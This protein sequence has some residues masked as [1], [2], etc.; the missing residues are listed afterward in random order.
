VG[1]IQD[2]CAPHRTS[3]TRLGGS[4][5]RHSRSVQS[6]P[7]HPSQWP[8][9][10]VRAPDKLYY[11]DKCL[12]FGA[13]PSA[14]A[15]GHVADAAAEI[16][17]SEG[18]GP[19]DKWVDDHVFFCVKWVHL[20]NYNDC[21]TAWNL[22]I[23]N[24]GP[25]SQSSSRL[26]WYASK[27]HASGIADE[28]NEDCSKPIQDLSHQSHRSEHDALFTYCLDDI[29]K[30][31]DRLGIP[32]EKS[33]DQ[34]FASSTTYISFVWDLNSCSVSLAIGKIE[35]YRNAIREWSNQPTHVLKDV[36]QLYSTLLHASAA[37]REGRAYL[38]GLEHMPRSARINL[39]CPT[40]RSSQ[41]PTTFYGG[42]NLFVQAGL[43]CPFPPLS[44]S[45]T[46]RLFRMPALAWASTLSSVA[47]GGHGD[48]SL[49]ERTHKARPEISDG[50]KQ[51][52]SKCSSAPSTFRTQDSP[53]SSYMVTTLGSLKDGG[54]VA[55]ETPKP[56]TSSNTFTPSLLKPITAEQFAHVTSQVQRTQRTVHRGENT[57]QH[58][59][60]FREFPSPLP[61]FPL[62]SMPMIPSP[63]S[64]RDSPPH[65]RNFRPTPYTRDDGTSKTRTPGG[66]SLAGRKTTLSGRPSSNNE[67]K[68]RFN[69]PL[70]SRTTSSLSLVSLEPAPRPYAPSL[71]PR[72]SLLCLHCLARNRL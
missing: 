56:T 11:I 31:S 26:V 8:A 54:Q 57:L 22:D 20:T 25:I 70:H 51:S 10:V 50:W 60:S 42:M 28:F 52:G 5:E 72:P 63:Q 19:L 6:H 61:L 13:A 69:A 16:F 24:S 49:A 30:I 66:E 21:R 38:T 43:N 71:T 2:R 12:L 62:S 65:P 44:H 67:H 37:L 45:Q 17:R 15:Y 1:N 59:S 46:Y 58:I 4:H 9:A 3:P 41:L 18:I 55:I 7:L 33:K 47:D 32:W 68:L 29:D 39:S 36:Q 35:K 64:S 27:D 14:R 23:Q 48:S 53:R 40:A 34:L